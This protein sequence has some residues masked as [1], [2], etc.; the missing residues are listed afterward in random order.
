VLYDVCST[1]RFFD[2]EEHKLY[3]WYNSTTPKTPPPTTV[4]FVATNLKEMIGIRGTMAAPVV[5]VTI[6]G[7][8]L[9]DA[10][11]T[12][13]EPWGVPSGG[14]WSL[15]RGGAMYIEGAENIT[16]QNNIFK[17]VDGNAVMISGYTR[18][19]Q[20]L[21]N[22]FSFIGDCAMAS[23]GYTDGDDN[24]GFSGEQPRHTLIKGNYARELGIF[25]LQSSMYFMAK[26]ALTTIGTVHHTHTQYTYWHTPYYTNAC[27]MMHDV[28]LHRGEPLFQRPSLRHQL[29]RRLRRWS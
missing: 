27:C 13:M 6:R 17:R 8:G 28:T 2:Q 10:A 26:T 25:Q 20:V 15:Y 4:D 7:V 11:A 22:D 9:R 12:F 5:G 24:E 21:D 18:G 19:V 1:P 23:W 14:D 3:Y 29:Q 16:V